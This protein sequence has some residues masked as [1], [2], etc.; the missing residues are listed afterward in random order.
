MNWIK[1][2]FV[3]T[4]NKNLFNVYSHW[5]TENCYESEFSE[6]VWGRVIKRRIFMDCEGILRLNFCEQLGKEMGWEVRTF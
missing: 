6:V 5:K 2:D 3:L 4:H 1:G